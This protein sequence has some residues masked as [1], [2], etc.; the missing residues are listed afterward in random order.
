MECTIGGTRRHLVDVAL[1]QRELG[2][3]VGVVVST[4]RD[5]S[6]PP[7][8]ERMRAAGVKVHVL[9]MLRRPAPWADFQ[10]LGRIKKI[11]RNFRPD[12][13]HTHSSKAGVLG[14][15]ASISTG[16]GVRVH[17]PHTFSFLFEALFSAPK[18]WLYRTIERHY[19]KSTQTFVA[20][21]SG[22]ADTFAQAGFIDPAKVAVVSNGIDPEPY[23]TATPSEESFGLDPNGPLVILVGLIYAAKGQDLA[24]AALAEAGLEQVQLLCVGPGD[25]SE[26][27]AQAKALGVTERVRFLGPRD[28]VPALMARADLLL[29]PSRWEGL[30]YVV[31]EA[32]A[33]GMPV[34]ATPVDGA[35]EVVLSG[36]TGFLSSAINAPSVAAALREALAQSR[37]EWAQ[38]GRAGQ[39]RVAK[40]YSLDSMVRGLDRVYLELL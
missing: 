38:M 29:L 28:D 7:D 15:Q 24:L 37:E 9:D 27:K 36:V 20:V 23:A 5:E 8:L 11:L 35:R 19:A 22:E 16:I 13:V 10:H 6:F 33:R 39:E 40:H 31:L 17:T 25:T 14:R 30:P 4:L 12:I 1:G 21:G 26:L 3:E 34:V 18:R 2:Y 32:M